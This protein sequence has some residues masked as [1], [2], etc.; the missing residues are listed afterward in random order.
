M[1]YTRIKVRRGS[2]TDWA[3]AD[4]SPVL[5][6]GEIGFE[7]DTNRFKIGNGSAAWSSLPYAAVN[8]TNLNN[9]LSDYILAGDLGEPQ[10]PAQL[11]VDGNLIVPKSSIIFEGA[12]ADSYQT[13]I[14]VTDPTADR[15]L[16]IPN[17]TGIIATQTYVDK[18]IY[19]SEITGTSHT[20]STSNLYKITEI[21]NSSDITVTI[22]SDPTDSDFPIGSSLEFRQMGTGR[23]IFS[24]TSPATLVS[25]DSYT[26]TRTQ[27]SSAILEK[28]ASNAW[29]LTGDIDA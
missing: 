9:T 5:A 1:S 23:I 19:G 13:T 11:D 24:V 27:Y 12:T 15:T 2:E 4:P 21:T 29:I 18:I 16:T 6:E 3:T 17:E 28:R 14:T 10:G 26:K 25:T 20:V 7:L 22:P 8:P